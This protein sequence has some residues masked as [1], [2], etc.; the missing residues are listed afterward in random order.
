M[1][2]QNQVPK[3]SWNLSKLLPRSLKTLLAF[4]ETL[5]YFEAKECFAPSLHPVEKLHRSLETNKESW[6]PTISL[7]TNSHYFHWANTQPN[8]TGKF[9]QNQATTSSLRFAEPFN[10]VAVPNKTLFWSY[11]ISAVIIVSCYLLRNYSGIAPKEP[12]T[13]GKIFSLTFQIS[14]DSLLQFWYFSIFSF[15]FS[16]ILL[17]LGT[18][19]SM[20]SPLLIN[21]DQIRYPS[22]YNMV[23][24]NIE[25]PQDF[26]LFIL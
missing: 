11:P 13:N 9:S 8:Y 17:S 15:S 18:A 23:S 10:I 1:L 21:H 7:P 22:F 24:L 26:I 6:R 3:F 5:Q 14:C 4:S 12:T 16:S 2:C 19:K 25:I 20:I